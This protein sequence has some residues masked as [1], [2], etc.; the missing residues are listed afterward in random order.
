[1]DPWLGPAN[2]TKSRTGEILVGNIVPQAVASTFVIARIISKAF[3]RRKWGADDTML[4]IAWSTSLVLTTLSCVLTNY[5]AGIHASELPPW[6]LSTNLKLQY[7]SLLFYILTLSL[8]KLT[9]C[10]FYL[11]IFADPLNRR[12]ALALL[13]FIVAYTL[14]LLLLSIFQCAPIAANWDKQIASSP[15]TRCL[16]MRPHFWACAAC[17]ILAD[18]LLAAQVVPNILPLQLPRRQKAA[19]LAVVSLGWLVVLASVIRLVRITAIP[20]ATT[21]AA[22]GDFTWA[23]YDVT[24]WSAVEVDTGLV[25]VAAPATKPL[26]KRLAPGLWRALARGEGGDA[27]GGAGMR[28][29]NL[30]AVTGG[31]AGRRGEEGEEEERRA[32]KAAGDGGGEGV[33]AGWG[34]VGGMVRSLSGKRA[35]RGSLASTSSAGS[36]GSAGMGEIVKEVDVRVETAERDLELGSSPRVGLAGWRSS[37]RPVFMTKL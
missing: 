6:A 12:L 32:A 5:G 24:I 9:I 27:D 8:T 20:A 11:S 10:L 22:G 13:A 33:S 25:C 19:L 35:K 18:A 21:A 36:A 2:A 23:S 28:L 30:E 17:N 15:H 3:I 1:M 26:V 34:Y 37:W 31:D 7:A 16:P 14:P 4:C 29:G